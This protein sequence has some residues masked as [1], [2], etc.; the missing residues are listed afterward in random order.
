MSEKTVKTRKCHVCYVCKKKI[1]KGDT[2]VFVQTK[3]PRYDDKDF[4]TQVGIIY[5]NIWAH[6]RCVQGRP[7]R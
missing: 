5:T 4:S 7:I 3:E 6:I 2:A 1:E